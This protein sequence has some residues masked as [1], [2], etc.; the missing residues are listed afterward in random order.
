MLDQ[1]ID[2]RSRRYFA[3][4]ALE[5]WSIGENEF[6]SERERAADFTSITV[7]RFYALKAV[8]S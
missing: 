8:E 7:S 2:S 1:M 5:W 4:V 3:A 6:P